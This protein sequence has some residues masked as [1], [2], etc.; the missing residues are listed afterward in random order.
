MEAFD[1]L[2]QFTI[3]NSHIIAG[4]MWDEIRGVASGGTLDD[5]V[6]EVNRATGKTGK[7][8]VIHTLFICLSLSIAN[9][10]ED[11]V[12]HFTGRLKELLTVQ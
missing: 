9:G 2:K 8:L 10:S 7:E 12:S 1:L 6:I 11:A 5:L 4:V 3:Q